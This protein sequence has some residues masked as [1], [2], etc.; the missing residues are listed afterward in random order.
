MGLSRVLLLAHELAG[1]LVPL[2]PMLLAF[3]LALELGVLSDRA[4][5]SVARGL[6]VYPDHHEN[7]IVQTTEWR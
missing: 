5:T 3:Y 1:R 6:L 7:C 4:L 2:G